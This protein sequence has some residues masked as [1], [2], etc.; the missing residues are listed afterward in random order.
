MEIL[1]LYQQACPVSRTTGLPAPLTVAE[2]ERA[3]DK[4]D[5]EFHAATETAASDHLRPPLC[6]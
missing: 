2:L 1:A 4:R 3:T 6:L 5:L